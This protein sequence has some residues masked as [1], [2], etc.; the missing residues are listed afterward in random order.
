[1]ISAAATV[2][3]YVS[4]TDEALRFWTERVGFEVRAHR[5]MGTSRWIEVAPPGAQTALV[6]YPKAIMRDWERRAPSVVFAA[7]DIEATCRAL[8]A[9][10]VALSQPLSDMPW[11]KFASFLD[12][13]GYEYG[14]REGV[15]Q[16][17]VAGVESSSAASA[18]GEGRA[19]DPSSSAASPLAVS[20]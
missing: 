1:M 11:G 3:V 19:G 14:I 8:E 9:N 13:E 10:D 20:R 2:A 18:A 17:L 7:T 16:A 5:P 4:D 15:G 12:P 6:L